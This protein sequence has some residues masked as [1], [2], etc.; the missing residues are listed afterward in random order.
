[1]KSLVTS[2]SAANPALRQ[3][4]V[5]GIREQLGANQ[6]SLRSPN[7]HV[8][9]VHLTMCMERV[10]KR[11]S[12]TGDSYT[13]AWRLIAPTRKACT[14]TWHDLRTN[15]LRHRTRRDERFKTA[16][17]IEVL[18][19]DEVRWKRETPEETR[20]QAASSGSTS[21]CEDP[22]DGRPRIE[23]GSPRWW[24]IDNLTRN[25]PIVGRTVAK[26]P[27]L[28]G[29][30]FPIRDISERVNIIEEN[31][32]SYQV[33]RGSREIMGREYTVCGAKVV[34][35]LDYSPP[36]R[37]TGFSLVE[38]VADEATGC[39]G[40]LEDLPFPPPL[41]SGAGP[42]S[43]RFPLMLRAAQ[44]S[45]LTHTHTR[46]WLRRSPPT[47]AIRA[48]S[49]PGSHV[50]IVLDNAACRRVFSGYF[51]SPLAFHRRSI[52]RSHFMSS[53]GMMGTYG[54]QLDSPLLGEGCLALSSLPTRWFIPDVS[55]LMASAVASYEFYTS[56]ASPVICENTAALSVNCRR[57]C[58]GCVLDYTGLVD[59]TCKLLNVSVVS[60]S[61]SSETTT[62]RKFRTIEWAVC[63]RQHVRN[64]THDVIVAYPYFDF[65][66]GMGGL[67]PQGRRDDMLDDSIGERP[68]RT[69]VPE[70]IKPVRAS[71]A[72][73][74]WQLTCSPLVFRFIEEI[75]GKR[76]NSATSPTREAPK[77]L[78]G[79]RRHQSAGVARSPQDSVEEV[80]P[81]RTLR[82][83]CK[84]PS[85]SQPGRDACFTVRQNH[86]RGSQHFTTSGALLGLYLP[87]GCRVGRRRA[88][89][90]PSTVA[91]L[92][93]EAGDHGLEVLLAGVSSVPREQDDRVPAIA[94]T[95]YT[96]P[97]SL[98]T[99][100]VN[101]ILH[102]G[103]SH[104]GVVPDDAVGRRF[105]SGISRFPRPLSFRRCSILT[106]I[107]LVGSRDLDAEKRGLYK[108]GMLY[109]SA[110]ATTRRVLNGRVGTR[111]CTVAND[112]DVVGVL[113][114]VVGAIGVADIV[115]VSKVQ[116]VAEELVGLACSGVR[117]E[118][119]PGAKAKPSLGLLE[120]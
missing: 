99:F 60:I 70:D 2:C 56:L 38:I 109:K 101:F 27:W 57:S 19:A 108:D 119:S 22:G 76:P 6:R 35:R 95:S 9:P 89:P 86:R 91:V 63:S 71:P 120:D 29:N 25:L 8:V 5:K 24:A 13:H 51:R 92:G 116:E 98:A 55:N 74:Y 112:D 43:P 80:G 100:L 15:G 44:I 118:T 84:I 23:P 72:D 67:A 10:K 107:T 4:P 36:P 46:T 18:R 75:G 39:R 42:H 33:S 41:H 117:H 102:S 21:T 106:S 113:L 110:I 111:L 87:F 103:F 20:L 66:K 81:P 52:L 49:P 83:K 115:D 58:A 85:V 12:D 17:D 114:L 48:R 90:S 26:L 68:P 64:T 34:R 96:A 16:L 37:R 53:P 7:P 47:T 65:Q 62:E 59:S 45:P 82:S 73:T 54:S 61:C 28:Y 78:S 94:P 32:R 14:L 30:K 97:P 50:G 1:M 79:Y 93:V 11:G 31:L 77:H 69:Y 3:H 40:F 105:F 104:V 88:R